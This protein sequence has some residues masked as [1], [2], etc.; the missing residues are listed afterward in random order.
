MPDLKRPFHWKINE[1]VVGQVDE[2]G[3]FGP[4]ANVEKGEEAD[5]KRAAEIDACCLAEK[6]RM[7]R[8]RTSSRCPDWRTPS[9]R[10]GPMRNCAA[11]AAGV[12]WWLHTRKI[13]TQSAGHRDRAAGPAALLAGHVRQ[14]VGGPYPKRRV[15]SSVRTSRDLFLLQAQSHLRK[16]NWTHFVNSFHLFHPRCSVGF[17]K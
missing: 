7:S 4:S 12:L 1:G 6:G 5:R 17:Q 2:A 9:T 8:T 15:M 10:V 16:Q 13:T 14:G 3:K 11:G